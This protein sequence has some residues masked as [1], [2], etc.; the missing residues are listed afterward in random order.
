MHKRVS[1]ALIS[2]CKNKYIG[3]L[4]KLFSACIHYILK[5]FVCVDVLRSSQPFFSQ[6]WTLL[7]WTLNYVV[8]YMTV[9]DSIYDSFVTGDLDNQDN[10]FF[11]IEMCCLGSL[12]YL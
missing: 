6:V 1:T 11:E 4:I 7:V 5:Y 10:T 8:P 2:Q 12:D 3:M 9:Y